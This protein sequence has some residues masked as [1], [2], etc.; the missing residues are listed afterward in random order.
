MQS[1]NGIGGERLKSTYLHQCVYSQAR[2]LQITLNMQAGRFL[3]RDRGVDVLAILESRGFGLSGVH[4]QSPL[5]LGV[6]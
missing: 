6:S 1:L 3:S 2:F 4:G 5:K